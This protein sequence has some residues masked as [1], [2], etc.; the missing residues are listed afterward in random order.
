MSNHSDIAVRGGVKVTRNYIEDLKN[1]IVMLEE[2]NALKDIFFKNES[3]TEYK[4]C[5]IEC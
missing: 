2:K 4:K 3:K 1:K 5:R